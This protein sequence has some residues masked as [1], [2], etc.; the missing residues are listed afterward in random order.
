VSE[1]SLPGL[2]YET[3]VG[4]H[5]AE[6]H[7]SVP[8]GGLIAT[9][10]DSLCPQLL[11]AEERAVSAAVFARFGE[12]VQPGEVP[13]LVRAGREVWSFGYGSDDLEPDEYT[14]L[15]EDD[16][17]WFDGSP[18]GRAVVKSWAPFRVSPK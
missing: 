14:T 9:C 18:I 15:N 11:A 16:L 10:T 2:I 5:Y 1:K 6:D 12:L 3:R 4:L 8:A 17:V 13:A 7:R